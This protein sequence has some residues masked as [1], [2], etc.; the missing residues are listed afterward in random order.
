MF[1]FLMTRTIT[2]LVSIVY[3]VAVISANSACMFFLYQ[4][5]LPDKVRK[6]RKF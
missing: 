3:S 1:S 4:Q 6:L 2:A 5:H